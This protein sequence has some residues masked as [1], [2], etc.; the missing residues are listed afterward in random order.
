MVI[1]SPTV[2]AVVKEYSSTANGMS[3]VKTSVLEA[4]NVNPLESYPTGNENAMLSAA[5]GSNVDSCRY[6]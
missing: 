2:G 3:L 1:T 5:I 6:F 4:P